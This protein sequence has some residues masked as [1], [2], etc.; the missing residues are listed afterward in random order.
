MDRPDLYREYH[1]ADLRLTVEICT[2]IRERLVLMGIDPMLAV[3]LRVGDEAAAELAADEAAA[4]LA[5]DEL[6]DDGEGDHDTGTP[7]ILDKKIGQ[8]EARYRNGRRPDFAKEP[9]VSLL[10][11]FL[12]SMMAR[13][14]C[15][16]PCRRPFQRT[17]G[18]GTG[19][20]LR[21][22]TNP[23]NRSST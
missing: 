18:P 9:L 14:Y 7:D 6:L 20:P 15:R 13:R 4:E 3:G 19:A 8:I 10:A 21:A 2:Y 16:G 23:A 1:L 17:A 12:P 11:F 22:T 5:T